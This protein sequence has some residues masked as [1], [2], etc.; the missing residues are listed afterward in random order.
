MTAHMVGIAKSG[1]RYRRHGMGPFRRVW[2]ARCSCG[3]RGEG[4]TG[5][6]AWESARLDVLEHLERTR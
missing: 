5:E 2:A 4:H 6:G 1:R 3:W